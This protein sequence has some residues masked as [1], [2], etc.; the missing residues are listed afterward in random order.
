MAPE[1]LR[2]PADVD[3]RRISMR[4]AQSLSSCSPAGR[5]FEAP[6]ISR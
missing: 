4:S 1:R 5:M 2:N 3:A 6:T